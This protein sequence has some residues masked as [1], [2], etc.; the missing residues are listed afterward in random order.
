M[1]SDT[2][3]GA[4]FINGAKT[5][6]GVKTEE[7]AATAAQSIDIIDRRRR[8]PMIAAGILMISLKIDIRKRARVRQTGDVQCEEAKKR[9]D[10]YK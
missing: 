1:S 9:R 5:E 3:A 7:M 6:R 2:A 4:W 8:T 10:K